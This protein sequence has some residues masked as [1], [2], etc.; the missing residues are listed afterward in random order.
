LKRAGLHLSRP[1][2]F[3]ARFVVGGAARAAN[4]YFTDN[5][6]TYDVTTSGIYDITAAGGQGAGG[7]G[8]AIIGGDVTLIA[9][10]T[11]VILVGGS[12]APAENGGGGGT[13]CP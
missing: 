4:F 10:E 7:G 3:S 5:V 9:G 2:F 11:L 12:G 6:Q 1:P 8:R 13:P